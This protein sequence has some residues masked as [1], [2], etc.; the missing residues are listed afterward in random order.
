MPR[1]RRRP[2]RARDRLTLARGALRH[3]GPGDDI[4]AL[5]R[6]MGQPARRLHEALDREINR[7]RVLMAP[8]VTAEELVSTTGLPLN[9]VKYVMRRVHVLSPLR[10]GRGRIPRPHGRPRRRRAL[11]PPPSMTNHD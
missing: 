4:E 5:G 9:F 3:F 1:A 7:V 11:T 8:G 10:K 2:L 6:R